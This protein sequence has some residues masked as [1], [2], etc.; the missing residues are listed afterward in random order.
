MKQPDLTLD[1]IGSFAETTTKHLVTLLLGNHRQDTEHPSSP[2][3]QDNSDI[4]EEKKKQLIDLFD[5]NNEKEWKTEKNEE[6]KNEEENEEKKIQQYKQ[7]VYREHILP[8]LKIILSKKEMEREQKNDTITK[9]TME[10]LLD[11][12][13][14][15]ISTY[16]DREQQEQDPWFKEFTTTY[17]LAQKFYNEFGIT[18][19]TKE[20]HAQRAL[21]ES[22]INSVYPDSSK[23]PFT[24]DETFFA[25]LQKQKDAN[26]PI[27]FIDITRE[28]TNRENLL[29]VKMWLYTLM[30]GKH[31]EDDSQFFTIEKN[32]IDTFTL[33]ENGIRLFKRI[34]H[35]ANKLHRKLINDIAKSEFVYNPDNI[36]DIQD[37]LL[38]RFQ[39][40]SEERADKSHPPT[41]DLTHLDGYISTTESLF[42]LWSQKLRD[43]DTTK[44]TFYKIVSEPSG[45]VYKDPEPR[46]KLY[47]LTPFRNEVIEKAAGVVST[48]GLK[49]TGSD[50]VLDKQTFLGMIDKSNTPWKW[51]IPVTDN[52]GNNFL[53]NG[54]CK[55]LEPI[56]NKMLNSGNYSHINAFNDIVWMRLE[57]VESNPNNA[58]RQCTQLFQDIM[59]TVHSNETNAPQ[60]FTLKGSYF[61]NSNTIVQQARSHRNSDKHTNTENGIKNNK[62][63]EDYSECKIVFSM[64]LN[65]RYPSREITRLVK[66]MTHS[67]HPER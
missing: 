14:K 18:A 64:D 26:H 49:I 30:A 48:L 25:E 7:R 57:A 37:I 27:T 10:K 24:I 52:N 42:H 16:H 32:N 47:D 5:A 43:Q 22:Y 3:T 55:E 4:I 63:A 46:K 61:K 20:N 13:T 56:T 34:F 28:E 67:M 1:K 2:W 40:E 29:H 19:T 65:C 51:S 62:T 39:K 38:G 60:Y 33:T 6:Q 8:Q 11:L 21:L 15:K 41:D 54:R 31:G 12:I 36:N 58:E 23:S 45:D 9:E 50:N 66:K 44:D 53:F 17:L 35:T 59:N